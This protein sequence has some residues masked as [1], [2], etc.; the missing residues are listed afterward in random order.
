LPDAIEAD[1]PVT[2]RRTAG[3]IVA[4]EPPTNTRPIG[5][6]EGPFREGAEISP[7][8]DAELRTDGVERI[9]LRTEHERDRVSARRGTVRT[10]NNVAITRKR[11][12][13]G[14]GVAH[15]IRRRREAE[16]HTAFLS[17]T[18]SLATI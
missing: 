17:D 6:C 3:G 2:K 7:D 11:F 12:C 10:G 14:R 9:G 13:R 8:R 5:R 15:V 1:T 18:S 4:L 16:L